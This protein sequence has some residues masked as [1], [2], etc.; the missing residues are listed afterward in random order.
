M[1]NTRITYLYRDACNYKSW[2]EE[3][4]R[5]KL[6]KE[7]LTPNLIDGEFF[8]PGEVGLPKLQPELL[9]EEDHDL[10]TIESLEETADT[11]TI[12]LSSDELL[13]AFER[14]SAKEWELY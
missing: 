7:Q 12:N 1:K 13:K 4:I 11:P 3:I 5:G 6:T 10:H 2:G 8:I 9:T 14:A